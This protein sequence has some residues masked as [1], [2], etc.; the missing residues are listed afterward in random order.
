MKDLTNREIKIGDIVA[1]HSSG[2]KSLYRGYVYNIGEKMICVEYEPY[3][4]V[5]YSSLGYVKKHKIY[6]RNCVIIASE[7]P[8]TLD[9]ISRIL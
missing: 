6:P 9:K 3:G 4:D 1:F 2:Y 7:D 5:D 8:T